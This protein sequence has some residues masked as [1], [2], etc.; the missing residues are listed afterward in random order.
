MRAPPAASL[1]LAS[2]AVVMGLVVLSG[3][4]LGGCLSAAIAPTAEQLTG[5]KSVLVL[6][7]EP[8][9]LL[10]P[11]YVM[12]SAG[13]DVIR[14]VQPLMSVPVPQ[15]AA[16][17]N[18]LAAGGGILTL[19]ELATTGKPTGEPHK[20][21]ELDKATERWATVILRDEAAI[22]LR[23]S[24][25]LPSVSVGTRYRQLD[26]RDRSYTWHMENWY[27]PIRAW[28]NDEAADLVY[29]DVT[30]DTDAV[31]E[32]GLLNFEVAGPRLI[33][34][35]MMRFLAPKTGRL[36]GRA[37]KASITKLA[38][39]RAV[40]TQS[41]R[42]RETFASITRPLVTACLG[43]LRLISSEHATE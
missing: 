11:P 7:V 28:Y 24:G 20:L 27:K 3:L 2:T 19:V 8:P 26:V 34:R 17:A 43:N 30:V 5:V 16:G 25:A 4:V 41:E 35:V 10:G 23:A 9:P 42:F 13:L 21:V 31:L 14:G 32:V 29:A 12:K 6:P 36:I 22:Q 40:V 33:V 1:R 18:V 37:E 15:I 39:I 38:D